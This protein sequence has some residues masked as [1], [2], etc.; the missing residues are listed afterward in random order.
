MEET[1]KCPYCGETIKAEAVKCR[2]CGEWLDETAEQEEANT[3]QADGHRD[4]LRY[5]AGESRTTNIP[6]RMPAGF[7]YVAGDGDDDPTPPPAADTTGTTDSPLR[8]EPAMYTGKQKRRRS[9]RTGASGRRGFVRRGGLWILLGI[10]LVAIGASY[11]YWRDLMAPPQPPTPLPVAADSVPA[12]LPAAPDTLTRPTAEDSLRMQDSIA[13]VERA[14][15]LRNRQRAQQ[16]EAAAAAQASSPETDTPPAATPET[17]TP[18]PNYA[19][20]SP[21]ATPT[22]TAR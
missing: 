14:R 22:D 1:K 11:P 7:S 12:A 3:P 21:R 10:V 4:R 13:R 16:A 6:P 8:A 15:Y 19:H 20:P 18:P 5:E 17:T 9:R 2:Y